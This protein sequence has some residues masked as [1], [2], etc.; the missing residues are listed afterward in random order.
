VLRKGA[1][2]D[3]GEA[4]VPDMS[5]EALCEILSKI[6]SRI[7]NL[8]ICFCGDELFDGGLVAE[9]DH[10]IYFLAVFEEN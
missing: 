6:L 1:A 7:K 10:A 3:I 2:G 4:H 9:A 5:I 8:A